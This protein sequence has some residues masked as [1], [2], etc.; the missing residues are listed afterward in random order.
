MISLSATRLKHFISLWRSG[1]FIITLHSSY[2]FH[3]TPS[4]TGIHS[5]TSSRS[6]SLPSLHEV[7][8]HHSST[9][10]PALRSYNIIS[11][12]TRTCTST[13]STFLLQ[14]SGEAAVAELDDERRANLF[15]LMLRDLQI[16]NVPLLG[17]DAREVETMNAALWTTMSELSE[18][19]D[20][21]KVCMIME[22]IPI[23]A[24]KAFATDY[25][26]LMTQTRLMD[27][28]PELQRISVSLLGN[29]VGPALIIETTDRTAEEMAEKTTRS[30]VEETLDEFRCTAALKSFVDR[31]V[32]GLEACPYTKTPDLS[33]TGLEA[34][35][36]DPGPVG[37]RFSKSSDACAAVASFWT[38]VCELL[39]VPETEISTTL[40]SL[41]AI[42]PGCNEEAHDR[43]AA[44]VELISRNLCLFRGD[45]VVGL[46]HFHPFYQRNL[47]HP[48]DKPAFGHLPP[49]S[50]LRSMLRHNGNEEAAKTLTD[51]DL[52]MSNY[53]RRSPHTMINI[54]RVSQLN[55]AVGAKSI[56]DLELEYGT[57]EKASGITLYS[58]NAI[59]LAEEGKDKLQEAVD[60]EVNMSLGKG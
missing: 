14:S 53:Q 54:L 21:Q 46:V 38:S 33:A 34:R 12:S 29:G 25:G 47:I 52:D 49:Q 20:G 13:S 6:P 30:A 11:S 16:E 32:V 24:L 59:R 10:F 36:V 44:V 58:R 41:P 56:V 31:I 15:Q 18:I 43:F 26:N 8:S 7:Q 9:S 22:D 2:A 23:D 51:E 28:L 17:C 40:L 48:V 27:Q 50:W 3:T 60:K 4:S 1:L 19:D 39:S 35:G 37:Y 45:A 55:A 42:G 57:T 5:I